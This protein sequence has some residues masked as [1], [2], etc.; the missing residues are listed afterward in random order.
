MLMDLEKV[1]K[2]SQ[3]DKY[4]ELP[5]KNYL[6]IVMVH[7]VK[8]LP[9]YYEDPEHKSNSIDEFFKWLKVKLDVGEGDSILL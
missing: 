5:L 9:E 3:G 6:R 7:L 2:I 8:L 4:V 1:I